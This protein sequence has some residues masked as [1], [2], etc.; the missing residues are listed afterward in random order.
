[1]ALGAFW[2]G[3]TS[4][5]GFWDVTASLLLPDT[6]RWDLESLQP[7]GVPGGLQ[8]CWEDQPFTLPKLR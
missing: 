4:R 1:M 7:L 6:T 2:E 8:G 5:R 3:W